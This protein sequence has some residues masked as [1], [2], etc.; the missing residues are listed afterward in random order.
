MGRLSRGPKGNGHERL[1]GR[2]VRSDDES[3][4]R[5]VTEMIRDAVD[6]E[7]TF[8]QDTLSMGVTG[9]SIQN[10]REYLEYVADRRLMALQLAPLYGSRNPFA[11]RHIRLA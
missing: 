9:L 2:F 5:S 1:M 4:G 10:M 3:F 8:A 6:C 11:F 7:L